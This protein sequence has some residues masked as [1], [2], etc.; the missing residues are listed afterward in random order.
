MLTK[1]SKLKGKKPSQIRKRVKLFLYGDSGVG[2]TFFAMSFPKPY[3]ID[4]ERGSEHSQY[5]DLLNKQDGVLYQTRD[6]EDIYEQ[7]KALA[8]E[9]HDYETLVIDPL[10]PIYNNLLDANS[11]KVGIAHGRHY[12][13]TN[14]LFERLLDLLLRIDMNVIITSHAKKLYD[15]GM[16][17][18]GT[19]FDCYKKVD[20][21]FDLTLEVKLQNKN[22]SAFVKKSRLS[23]YEVDDVVIFTYDEFSKRYNKDV[24][25][26]SSVPLIIITD[27]TLFDLKNLI[28]VNSITEDTVS[29]WLI[30]ANVKDLD[31]LTE[32]QGNALIKK[33]TKE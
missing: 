22:R 33:L 8:S 10:T 18:A 32:A 7:V 14:K 4:T 28:D 19:T 16:A 15:D 27:N 26:G 29:K 17:I 1:M 24:T 9:K 25:S 20:Y 23:N 31:E 12:G 11:K 21:I 6:F 5:V 3:Y 2:K 30:H 13:E